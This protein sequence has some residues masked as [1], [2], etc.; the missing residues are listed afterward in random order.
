M[1]TSSD[2]P[3]TAPGHRPVVATACGKVILLGEH[4][5]VYGEPALAVPLSTSRLSVVLAEPGAGWGPMDLAA[6]QISN[7]MGIALDPGDLQLVGGGGATQS[8]PSVGGQQVRPITI[9]LDEGAPE[10]ASDDIFRALG[11]AA[12]AL[13]LQLPLPLRMAVR[14]GGLRSGMGTSA[15]LG[16][17]LGRAL[18][19][20][21][22]LAP[23]RDRVLEAAA[24]VERMFHGQPSGID[25]TVSTYEQP[26]W[27]EK[28]MQP[29]PLE[30]MP[31]LLVV[32]RPG[33]SDAGTRE[34]VDG[35]R[36]RLAS[37]PALVRT[38]AEIGR[39]SRIG[40][41]AWAA[42]QSR[43][44]AQAMVEQQGCLEQ[45]GVV[46]DRDREGIHT[47][48]A[49]GALAAKI[50]GAGWGGTLLALVEAGAAPQVQRAWGPGSF[51]LNLGG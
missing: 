5:V 29:T 1:T 17:A 4:A 44:L 12:Q 35:V 10:G 46:H 23:D 30:A 22:G 18:L 8:M 32:V 41:S 11:S 28:G 9:T 40:R 36:A 21:Y 16:T 38:I 7:Q 49:A 39:W 26:V 31:P 34:I 47:A 3:D 37:E 43:G 24:A 48:V 19:S 20:W 33:A 50:T 14:A 27:Y 51:V 25:H 42:G 6:A 15:A 45:L 13:G 2:L